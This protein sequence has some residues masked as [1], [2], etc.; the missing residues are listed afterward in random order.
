MGVVVMM[1]R[2]KNSSWDTMPFSS[3][4]TVASICTYLPTL[5]TYSKHTILLTS[6]KKRFTSL[7]L[8]S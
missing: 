8:A 5:P 4:S 1:R 2:K 6:F 3:E 7:Q